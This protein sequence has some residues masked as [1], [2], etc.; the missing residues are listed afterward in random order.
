[1]NGQRI[2][3]AHIAKQQ[4]QTQIAAARY[5]EIGAVELA[6]KKPIHVVPAARVHF[7]TSCPSMLG[8]VHVTLTVNVMFKLGNNE[9]LIADYAFNK[10]TNRNDAD[11]LFS[12]QDR[13]MPYAPL[14]H[15]GHTFF[16]GLLWPDSNDIFHDVPHGR[17][18]RSFT[19]ENNLAC[20]M[21]L[22]NDTN[23]FFA[24]NHGQRSNVLVSHFRDGFEH[25]GVRVN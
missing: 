22:S 2:R 13:E 5:E 3:V 17:F 7:T 20:I 14:G 18:G 6:I 21:S 16:D 12:L 25:S 10:V 11:Q 15:D 8:K 9:F 1:M 4:Q 23:E 19:L 24:L